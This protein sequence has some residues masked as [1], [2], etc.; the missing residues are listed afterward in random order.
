[1]KKLIL[2]LVLM[3]T[4]NSLGQTAAELLETRY[5]ALKISGE[6]GFLEF[7]NDMTDKTYYLSY[8]KLKAANSLKSF[9][10]SPS[11]TNNT[12]LSMIVH[13][14]DGFNKCNEKNKII[15][16]FEDGSKISLNSWN[17]FNCK[18]VAYFDFTNKIASKFR[19]FKVTKIHLEN[20]DSY[21]SVSIDITDQWQEYFIKMT[22]VSDEKSW[23]KV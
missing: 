10:I 8:P 21:E 11:I 15:F 14:E 16:L 23:T 7:T 18:G 4:L 1:M 3:C 19:D 22:K 12:F 17:K 20:G 9:Q 13:F 5:S 6:V 2:L